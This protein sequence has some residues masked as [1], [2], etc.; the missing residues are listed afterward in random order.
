MKQE[1]LPAP[2]INSAIEEV[3]SR[4]EA[5]RSQRKARSKIPEALW[6]AAIELCE[7]H[8]AYEVSRALRL[9]YNDLRSRIETEK[10]KA[11]AAGYSTEFVELDLRQSVSCSECTLEME[12]AN[13]A[14][15]KMHFRGQSP[16]DPL[17]MARIFWR[18]GL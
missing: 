16:C 3:R 13:G 10:A 7:T 2:T 5:W 1:I 11:P 6:Q 15:M 17:Q 18:Q 8:S 4:F 9:N 12:A 14:K